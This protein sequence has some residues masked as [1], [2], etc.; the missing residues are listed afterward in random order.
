MRDPLNFR[1]VCSLAFIR[2]IPSK[3]ILHFIILHPG[4]AKPIAAKPKVDF[5]APDSPIKPKTS[6]LLREISTPNIMSCHFSS[7]YPC[8]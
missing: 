1:F 3:I 7:L 2:S 4:L 8:I 6:P 5:P